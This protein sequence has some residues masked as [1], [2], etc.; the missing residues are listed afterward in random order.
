MHFFEEKRIIES[1]LVDGL[2]EFGLVFKDLSML[3]NAL[4]SLVVYF[5]DAPANKVILEIN[6][7]HEY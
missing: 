2:L 3:I 6:Y 7:K 5:H 4:E 1:K